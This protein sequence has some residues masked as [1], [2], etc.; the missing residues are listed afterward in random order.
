MVRFETRDDDSYFYPAAV[1]DKGNLLT[2][3]EEVRRFSYR[4]NFDIPSGN[5]KFNVQIAFNVLPPGKKHL[6]EYPAGTMPRYMD[7]QDTDYEYALNQCD[8]GGTEV[9]C[10]GQPGAPRK[11][12]Y[13]RQPKSPIDGGPVKDAKLVI[14][15]DVLECSIPWSEM[16]EVKQRL[17]AGEPIKFSFRVN[18]GRDAYEL[19]V[20]RSVSKE[21]PLAFH[22][23]FA[24]HWANELEF[25]FEK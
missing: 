19:T 6:L 16:P 24:T 25:G 15:G 23:D 7:Y 20:E 18:A 4:K 9:F 5:G 11:H 22:N 10:L 12:F 17:D 14:K 3:P 2:W 21:N 8:D 1:S 13:P